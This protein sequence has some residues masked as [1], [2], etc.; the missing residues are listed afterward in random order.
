MAIKK[1]FSNDPSKHLWRQKIIDFVRKHY[2]EKQIRNLKVLCLPG[3]EMLEVFEIYDELG[4]KRKN[5]VGL[6]KN[7]AEYEALADLNESLDDNI[8]V[9]YTGALEY[10]TR[11]PGE[12]QDNPFDIISLDYYGYQDREKTDTLHQIGLCG[13]LSPRAIV[14]TNYLMARENQDMQDSYKEGEKWQ[15]FYMSHLKD[16]GSVMESLQDRDEFDKF[17]KEQQDIDFDID[18]GKRRD[19]MAQTEPIFALN[20]GTGWWNTE[21]VKLLCI[22]RDNEESESTEKNENK[23]SGYRR[24]LNKNR[25]HTINEYD[26]LEKI[27]N[28]IYAANQELSFLMVYYANFKINRYF[29]VDDHESYKYISNTGSPMISDFFYFEQSDMVFNDLL[30][31]TE[32]NLIKKFSK[33]I[34]TALMNGNATFICKN[35]TPSK[36]KQIEDIMTTILD[37]R[38]EHML[39]INTHFIKERTLLFPEI[40][41]GDHERDH[42][43]YHGGK[44]GGECEVN[45]I[46]QPKSVQ[47]TTT[48]EHIY[49]DIKS[50]RPDDEIRQSYDLGKMQLAGYKAALKR[51]EGNNGSHVGYSNNKT[52]NNTKSEEI[53][54]DDLEY[55]DSLIREGIDNKEIAALFEDRV[56]WQRIAARKRTINNQLNNKNKGENGKVDLR[57]DILVRDNYECQDCGIANKDHEQK[58]NHGLHI[59]HID[60]DNSNNDERNQITLCCSCHAKTNLVQHAGPLTERLEE[61]IKIIYTNE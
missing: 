9:E 38:N 52:N 16:I 39:G 48:K 45:Q 58:Y 49:R 56:T 36:N 28:S 17:M 40:Y 60:Y 7:L 19:R 43:G 32:R 18:I 1:S 22:G 31:K 20:R 44:Y 25:L 61:K 34:K 11:E 33:N 23:L 51:K 54:P 35:R 55:V 14:F 59:H 15:K 29:F 4:V 37:F 5:I 46:K 6:E 8:T 13:W 53:S 47:K 41:E 3:P 10:L 50:G 30:S 57:I 24:K 2:S 26:F 42:E 12:L 27:E 21:I